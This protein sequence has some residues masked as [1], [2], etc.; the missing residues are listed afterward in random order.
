MS[1]KNY[2]RPISFILFI[3]AIFLA[4]YWQKP[5]YK[6]DSNKNTDLFSTDR[7]LNHLSVIS[8]KPHYVGTKEHSEVRKYIINELEKLGLSVSVQ[9]QEVV[10]SK[11]QGGTKVYNVVTQIK[12]S[13]SEKSLL[14]LTHYD[15]SPHSSYGASD[16]GSGVVTILESLRAYLASGKKPKNDI[17]ILISDAEELGLLGAK[18][19]VKY[20]PLAKNVGLVINLEARGSGGP[21]Y[22]LLETNGGNHELI[23]AFDNANTSHPVGNSLLYSLYKMLPN[24]TDLTVFRKDA[25]IDGFNFAFI[26]D[27]YDYHTAQDTFDR[28]DKSSLA[29]QGTYMFSLL[30]YFSDADLTHLKGQDDDVFFNFPGFGMVYYPFNTVLPMSIVIGILFLMLYAY[31]IRKK[32]LTFKGSFTSFVPF[33]F[34]LI[35]AAI[36][37]ILG[38]KIILSLFPKYLDILHGFTYNGQLYIIAFSSLMLGSLFWIYHKYLKNSAV[39]DLMVAPIVVW[40][41]VNLVFGITLKGGGFFIIPLIG[42]MISWWVLLYTNDRPN[43][44]IWLFTLLAIPTLFIISPLI[45]LLP[46]GLG[47]SNISVSLVLIVLVF[48]SVLAVFGYYTNSKNLSKFF[49]VVALLAFIVAYFKS[50]FTPDNK[51]PNSIVFIQDIDKNEAFWASYNLENDSFTEQFLGTKPQEGDLSIFM[52]SKFKTKLKLYKKTAVKMIP[53]PLIKKIVNDNLFTD[54]DVIEYII[55]PQRPS[56]LL[57]LSAKDSIAFYDISFNGES[58]PVKEGAI[59]S[60]TTSTKNPKIIAYHLAEGVDSLHVKMT[61]P[62]HQKPNLVLYDI[63]YDLLENPLFNVQPRNKNMMPTPFVINDAVILKKDL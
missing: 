50:D 34:S 13:S 22:M 31:G 25:N 33:L 27:F 52:S 41:I 56:N 19:F 32:K 35:I 16:A 21:S 12:G 17:T 57:Y 15:S 24:D 58:Y 61:I 36:L 63:S 37:G 14:L 29:H 54:K 46:V 8:K 1:K 59:Y 48:G 20:H 51:K 44:R 10:N 38:W 55:K 43:K 4:F 5:Q 18:A 7:A 45:Y 40:I 49:F 6:K 9:E 39:P 23:K 2:I 53:E 26:D 11:W 30:N 62:K 47:L 28:L 42:M 60:Y 3:A